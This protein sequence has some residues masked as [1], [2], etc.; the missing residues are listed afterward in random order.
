LCG[1]DNPDVGVLRKQHSTTVIV[2]SGVPRTFVS[3]FTIWADIHL[4]FSLLARTFISVFT[5]S[6]DI[7]L[8]FFLGLSSDHINTTS[9]CHL[10]DAAVSNKMYFLFPFKDTWFE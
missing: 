8:G 10:F 1:D 9:R 2:K 4:G 7:H 5:I 6:A 3:V